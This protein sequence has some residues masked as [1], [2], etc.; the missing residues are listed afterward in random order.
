VA[1]VD[2]GG[3]NVF[4]CQSSKKNP[5]VPASGGSI[6]GAITTVVSTVG[7]VPPPPSDLLQP[8][9]ADTMLIPIAQLRKNNFIYRLFKK[10]ADKINLLATLLL[11]QFV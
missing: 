7:G 2:D 9:N 6:A 11:H 10:L 1:S 8:P 5:I 4:G 3:V